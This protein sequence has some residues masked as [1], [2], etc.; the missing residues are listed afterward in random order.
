MGFITPASKVRMH[1]HNRNWTEIKVVPLPTRC[2]INKRRP[3]WSQQRYSLAFPLVTA[4][5]FLE[6]TVWV[7][8]RTRGRAVHWISL[9][10]LRGADEEVAWVS[11]IRPLVAKVVLLPVNIHTTGSSEAQDN[12]H[13]SNG[14][15]KSW[16]FM[17]TWRPLVTA[18][19]LIE[20]TNNVHIYNI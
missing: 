18:T 19:P 3:K 8:F 7:W 16:E 15:F 2:S 13:Y 5:H 9:D 1:H 6:F 14:Y 10:A 11:W 4:T 20:H 17:R 12:G